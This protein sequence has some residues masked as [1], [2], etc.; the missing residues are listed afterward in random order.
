MI[1]WKIVT[2]MALLAAVILGVLLVSC[3]PDPYSE[4]GLNEL[5]TTYWE[6]RADD[7]C[8][9]ISALNGLIRCVDREAGVAC[10]ARNEA[11]VCLPIS[12]TELEGWKE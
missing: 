8:T 4:P 11:L 10:W 3:G 2:M 7:S 6:Q 5:Q 12:E 9:V 1:H